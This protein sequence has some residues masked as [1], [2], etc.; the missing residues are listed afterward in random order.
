MGTV[1]DY[2][3][4]ETELCVGNGMSQ[5]HFPGMTGH[6]EHKEGSWDFLSLSCIKAA[7]YWN[8]LSF[9]VIL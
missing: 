8:S 1:I 2:A 4:G 5:K 6:D 9:T 7:A 3:G